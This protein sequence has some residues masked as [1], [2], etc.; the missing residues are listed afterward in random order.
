MKATYTKT[1]SYHRNSRRGE[2]LP[3]LPVT[4]TRVAHVVLCN[5]G[6]T[7]GNILTPTHFELGCFFIPKS[8]IFYKFVLR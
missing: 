7:V 4:A 2:P 1:I 3:G 6:G 5:S 8:G